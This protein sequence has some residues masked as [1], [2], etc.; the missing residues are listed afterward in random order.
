ML[1]DYSKAF[2]VVCHNVLLEKLQL[3]GID[4]QLLA[5]IYSFLSDRVM[6]VSVHGHMSSTRDVY[7]GVPQGSVLGPLLFLVYI[8]SIGS[9][10]SCT[11]KIFADDLKLFASVAQ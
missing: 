2:D 11:Y 7:S 9:K 1:F 10:L 5:W 3:I 8:N 4:D 6:Q